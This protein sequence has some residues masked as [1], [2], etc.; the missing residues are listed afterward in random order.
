MDRTL[1][2]NALALLGKSIQFAATS[3]AHKTAPATKGTQFGGS[4][5]TSKTRRKNAGVN[6]NCAVSATRMANSQRRPDNSAVNASH[7]PNCS[8]IAMLPETTS[9]SAVDPSAKVKKNRGGTSLV[10]S[11]PARRHMTI[12]AK[13]AISFRPNQRIFAAPALN[14]VNGANG[15]AASG[16]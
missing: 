1:A 16:G 13:N 2:R 7:R 6:L 10:R 5:S 12:V 14:A 3:P 15:S 8:K 4:S 9:T 11:T